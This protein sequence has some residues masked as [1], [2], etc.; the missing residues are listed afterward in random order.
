MIRDRKR[1]LRRVNYCVLH[2][3]SSNQKWTGQLQHETAAV[4]CRYI[5]A[6]DCICTNAPRCS[7]KIFLS[8]LCE[9]RR[10]RNS[11]IDP[12][13]G[14]YIPHMP[15]ARRFPSIHNGMVFRIEPDLMAFPSYHSTRARV[16]P[17]ETGPE[18]VTQKSAVHLTFWYP[19]A[20]C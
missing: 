16:A 5:Y 19:T 10:H 17:D 7:L 2:A 13:I 14:S 3:L 20:R 15:P 4:K 18:S 8:I 6:L 9:R 11:Y 12:Y 1:K